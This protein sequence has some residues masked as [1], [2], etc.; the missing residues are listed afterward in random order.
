MRTTFVALVAALAFGARS[1]RADAPTIQSPALYQCTVAAFVYTCDEGPCTIV[2]RPSDD[3]TSSIASLGSV[4]T[5]DSSISWTPNVAEGTQVTA[6]ITDSTGAV[7]NNSPTTVNEGTTDCMGA[8]SSSGSSSSAGDSSS[9]SAA[10][11]SAASSAESTSSR[12]SSASSAAS[13]AGSSA[14]SRASSAASAASSAASS[15]SSALSSATQVLL[16]SR[17]S[18]S[19]LLTNPAS[20]LRSGTASASAADASATDSGAKALAVSSLFAGVVALGVAALA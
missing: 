18:Y 16:P 11:S 4:D 15:A 19:P 6:Y 20:W 3:A 1:V 10:A 7:G 14:S 9:S 12:A 13:S 8:S 5:G 17:P 2:I